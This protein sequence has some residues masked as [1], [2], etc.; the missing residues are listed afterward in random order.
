MRA[1]GVAV[2]LLL[3]FGQKM[4]AQSMGTKGSSLFNSCKIGLANMEQP[5]KTIS[6]HELLEGAVCVSY[7]QGFLDARLDA[8][9]GMICTKGHSYNVIVRVYVK[10]MEE[11]PLLLDEHRSDGF[12]A[13]LLAGFPCNTKDPIS[14]K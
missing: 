4:E 7:V 6:N 8:T 2:F 10:F 11:N 3:L 12:R 1:T 5:E 9:D 14:P 13:A